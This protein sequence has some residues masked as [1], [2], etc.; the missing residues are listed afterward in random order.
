M[1]RLNDLIAQA[2]KENPR[3]GAAL[4]QEFHARTSRTFGLVFERHLPEE[5]ELPGRPVR[6][7]DNVHVLP[8][9]GSNDK[10]DPRTW[11]VAGITRTDEGRVANLVEAH[12][13][14]D[15]QPDTMDAV[16]V[17]DLVV[18]AEHD[19][20]IY[21]GLVQTGEVIGSDDEDAP[22]HSVINAEN[23]HALK[24]LTYTHY[25]SID[26]IYID[27]PYNT[28][29]KDWKYNNDYVDGEDGYRHSKWLSFMERRLLVAK[30]LLNPNDSVLI[31]TIDEKE[32]LRLGLLLEQTF[33]EAT[34]QMVSSVINPKG[35]SRQGSFAR[36]DEYLFFVRLGKSVASPQALSDEWKISEDKRA[37]KIRWAELLRSGSNYRRSDSENQFYPIFVRQGDNGPEFVGVGEPYFGS[38]LK[39]VEAPEGTSVIWPIRQNRDEG[40]WQISADNLRKKIESGYAKLGKWRGENTTVYYLK[41]GEER[42]VVSGFY[43]VIGRSSDNSVVVDTRDLKPTFIPGTQW[44]IESHNA[45]QGGTGIVQAMLPR[46]KFPFPK[47]LY[48]V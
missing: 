12:P 8:P 18:T 41:R 29:A 42:K 13:V 6:R 31:V 5:V 25:H 19:D 15:E 39:E 3:L 27:P 32:Y 23:Y 46:R 30:Q 48:A 4:E 34:I 2:K 22:F 33:P 20:V 7:G 11:R 44:R 35:A 16:P 37:K 10:P 47:S 1:S 26:C 40:N 38:D 9:R 36:V 14:T 45:E 43:K 21:P 28:G 24:M 17:A